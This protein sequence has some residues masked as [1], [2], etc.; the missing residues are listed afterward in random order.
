MS[1][2]SRK[3][4]F[5]ANLCDQ[6]GST[7]ENIRNIILSLVSANEKGEIVM[8]IPAPKTRGPVDPVPADIELNFG[9]ASNTP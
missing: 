1:D 4:L 6:N 8:T 5:A 7:T 2:V 9:S 3:L